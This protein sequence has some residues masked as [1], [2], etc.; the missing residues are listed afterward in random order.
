[1]YSHVKDTLPPLHD[2]YY[3]F[4]PNLPESEQA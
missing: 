4:V 1:M 3:I 2:K